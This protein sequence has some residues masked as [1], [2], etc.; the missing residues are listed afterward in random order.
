MLS[1]VCTVYAEDENVITTSEN[2]TEVG[3]QTD[4]KGIL[5]YVVVSEPNIKCGDETKILVGMSE[6]SKIDGVSADVINEDTNEEITLY[7]QLERIASCSVAGLTMLE[8]LC[9]III[10]YN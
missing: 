8:I 9:E 4:G 2:V 10:V 7:G 1:S 5:Q 6:P 3:N